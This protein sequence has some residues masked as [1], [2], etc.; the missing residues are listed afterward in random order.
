M[1]EIS[2]WND[3]FSGVTLVSGSVCH[4]ETQKC[5]LKSVLYIQLKMQPEKFLLGYAWQQ[6]VSVKNIVFG[7]K[8]GE[9]HEKILKVHVPH[10]QQKS[11]FSSFQK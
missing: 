4:V 5:N 7:P 6:Q 9:V 11:N 8:F 2:F 1:D 10:L 3:L